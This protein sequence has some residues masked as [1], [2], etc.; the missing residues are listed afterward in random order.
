M[1]GLHHTVLAVP[2]SKYNNVICAAKWT[3]VEI[4]YF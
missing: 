1:D 3:T 4:A 2:R